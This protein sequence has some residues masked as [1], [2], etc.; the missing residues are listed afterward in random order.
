MQNSEGIKK[1][2]REVSFLHLFL[3]HSC[4]VHQRQT[5]LIV[6]CLSL[7]RHFISIK[8][9][10]MCLCNPSSH[11]KNVVAYC[12]HCSPFVLLT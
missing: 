8:T 2:Y 5:M 7:Q 11:L 1:V 6:V 10:C 12:T 4:S 3:S 9:I